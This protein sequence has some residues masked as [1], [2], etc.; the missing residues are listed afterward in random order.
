MY[1]RAN[2]ADVYLREMGDR[3][4]QRGTE[5]AGEGNLANW[6]VNSRRTRQTPFCGFDQAITGAIYFTFRNGKKSSFDSP[7][8]TSVQVI[9]FKISLRR[10]VEKKFGFT[11]KN[12]FRNFNPIRCL[13]VART[14]LTCPLEYKYRMIFVLVLGVIC[15]LWRAVG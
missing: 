14:C 7:N 8:Y 15:A 13:R 6:F 3:T 5:I 9:H 4:V 2:Y 11:N 10:N 12:C 1:V